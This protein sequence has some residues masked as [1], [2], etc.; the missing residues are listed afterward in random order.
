MTAR[1]ETSAE[2]RVRSRR[3][4]NFV[5]RLIAPFGIVVYNRIRGKDTYMNRA[6]KG[7]LRRILPRGIQ[8]RIRRYR[9]GV[10]V[11]DIE[12]AW[13]FKRAFFWN[14]FKALEF[15][16]IDGDYAEFGFYS[17]MTFRL[18]Y[19]PIRRRKTPLRPTWPWL[20]STATCTPAR[21]SCSGF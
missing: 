3:A 13:E 8:S 1:L 16:G 19:D 14:A 18:A 10:A 6:L 17:G 4:G 2:N 15:N 12:A 20:T 21:G 9:Y 11:T 5:V 7:L